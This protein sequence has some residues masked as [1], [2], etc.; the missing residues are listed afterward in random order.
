MSFIHDIIK[1][2]YSRMGYL[3]NYPYHMISDREMFDAFI[4]LSES[5]DSDNPTFFAMNY[6]NPFA[7]EDFMYPK[8]NTSSGLVEEISLSGEYDR[9]CQYIRTTILRYLNSEIPSEDMIPN[10]IYSYMLGEVVYRKSPYK[11]ILDTLKLLGESN[12]D[13]DFTRSACVRCYATSLK[14]VSSLTSGVRPPTLFGEPHVIKQLRL[15]E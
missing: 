15:E 10:W 1:I 11:D 14:Y 8:K 7:K 5:V 9:L 3:P 12:L 6:P 4:G 13:N 2:K